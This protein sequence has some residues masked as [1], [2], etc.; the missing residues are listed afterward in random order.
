M[1]AQY[2]FSVYHAP[3]KNTIPLKNITLEEVHKVL[4]SN[5][6]KTV[7][8]ELRQTTDKDQQN[9]IKASKLDYVTFSGIFKQRANNGLL[10][11]SNLFC[12]DLDNLNTVSYTHL[13]LP[14]IYSV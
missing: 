12:I 4:I 8:S 10:Q 1:E 3:I 7:T 14:T 9:E 13:T 11:H 5:K 2:K 6:Y